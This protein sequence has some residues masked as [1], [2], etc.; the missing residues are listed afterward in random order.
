MLCPKNERNSLLREW[1]GVL[2]STPRRRFIALYYC[3]WSSCRISV[4]TK[5][6]APPFFDRARDWIGVGIPLDQLSQRHAASVTLSF[7]GGQLSAVFSSP[8]YATCTLA[9][10]KLFDTFARD[11][12]MPS[13]MVCSLYARRDIPAGKR[14]VFQIAGPV[15]RPSPRGECMHVWT[16]DYLSIPGMYLEYFFVT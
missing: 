14:E 1:Y 5:K 10:T 6:L 2:E 16:C 15:P 12:P 11:T 8:K 9:L 4:D 3:L 7:E 13:T